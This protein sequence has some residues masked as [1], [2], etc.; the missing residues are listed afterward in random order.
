MSLDLL[1]SPIKIGGIEISNRCILAPMGVG[2][3]SPDDTWSKRTIRYFEERAVGG[4]GLIISSN[5]RVHNKLAAG[6]APLIGIYDDRLIST[7]E[8][9]VKC[10]HKYDT[11]I[12]LQISLHGCKYGGTEGPSPIYSLNYN[13]KPRELTTS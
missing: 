5:T 6:P 7:H 1:F 3:S 4:V 11:K 13:V 8:E 9:L 2:I 10:I 12:F